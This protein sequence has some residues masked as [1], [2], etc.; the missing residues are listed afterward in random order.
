MLARQKQAI[1]AYRRVQ[2][3]LANHPPPES[4]GYVLQKK[5]IDEVVA[6][7]SEHSVSQLTGGRLTQA[8]VARQRALRKTLREDHLRPIAKIAR[9]TLAKAPGIERALKMPGYTLGTLRLVNEA[10][11]MR[12]AAAQYVPQFV[13]AGR[14][15]DFLE[16]LDKSVEPLLESM[17]GHSLNLGRKVGARAGID[18]EISRGR[19]AVEVLDTIVTTAF[20]GNSNVL[21]N[22]QNARRVQAV[23]GAG[24]TPSSSTSTSPQVSAA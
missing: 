11:A 18:L 2:V 10:K 9:A 6:T 20:R 12:D 8:E 13:D 17:T 21:A 15:A 16:Q 23:P 1:E 24:A 3:F 4:P 7:L 22:W 14:P 19:R 5:E